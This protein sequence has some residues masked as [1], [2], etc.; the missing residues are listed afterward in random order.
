VSPP[1]SVGIVPEISSD[2]K[3]LFVEF[4]DKDSKKKKK[5]KK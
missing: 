3:I 2:I 5:K 1:I 4:D